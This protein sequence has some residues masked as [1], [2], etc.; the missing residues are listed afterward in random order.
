M[1]DTDNPS[2]AGGAAPPMPAATFQTHIYHLASQVSM[3]L[4]HVENPVTKERNKDLRAAQFLIDTI[5]MLEDKTRG[6]LDSEEAQY[7]SGVLTNLRMEYVK[8]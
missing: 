6:N 5:A 1:S 3:A 8:G 4:G 2:I 7:I